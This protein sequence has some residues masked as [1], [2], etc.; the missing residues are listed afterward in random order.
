MIYDQPGPGYK[1]YRL[2]ALTKDGKR[3]EIDYAHITS[4]K[5]LKNKCEQL[6]DDIFNTNDSPYD[7][8]WIEETQ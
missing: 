3:V 8:V 5:G 1:I 7:D 6:K 2:V 4:Y